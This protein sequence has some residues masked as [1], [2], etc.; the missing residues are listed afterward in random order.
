MQDYIE[1]IKKCKFSVVK[2]RYTIK[3]H[4]YTRFEIALKDKETGLVV[5]HSDYADYILYLRHKDQSFEAKNDEGIYAVVQFLNYVFIDNYEK[6]GIKEFSDIT[7]EMLKDY[8]SYYS[9][10]KTKQGNTYPSEASVEAKRNNISIFLW[11]YCYQHP[12][13]MHYIR[14]NDLMEKEKCRGKDGF[15]HN[16]NNYKVKYRCHKNAKKR[17]FRDMPMELVERFIKMAEIYDPEMVLAIV[18]MAYAGLRK[19][20]VCNLRQKNGGCYAPGWIINEIQDSV[21]NNGV[22]E[23]FQ[24]CTSIELD[25]SD[26]LL[27][28]SDGVS[29]GSIKKERMQPVYPGYTELIYHYYKRHMKYIEGKETEIYKPLFVNKTPDKRTGKYMALTKKEL[30]KRINKLFYDHVVPSLEY[31]NNFK[32]QEFNITIK[33]HTWGPHSF[34]HWFTVSLVLKGCSAAE[35]QT[36]RGDKS[37]KSANAY[38]E[39]KGELQL[40]Y[41]G[42]ADEMA[43]RIIG[44]DNGE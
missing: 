23:V 1:Y 10:S 36:Y 21:V 7:V 14:C 24:R 22:A 16:R 2:T 12:N 42:A 44:D 28:R 6:Y 32:F 38:L 11:N 19:A 4:L 43:S 31:D 25:L 34:R 13:Y 3:G 26:E 37:P 5:W 33:K 8:L 9:N 18:L 30:T 40:L 15:T 27:L 29:V 35:I 41:E 20:E 17:L 39:R